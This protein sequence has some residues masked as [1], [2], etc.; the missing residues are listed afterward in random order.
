METGPISHK[1]QIIVDNVPAPE[2]WFKELLGHKLQADWSVVLVMLLLAILQGA[3]TLCQFPSLWMF[4]HIEENY[5]TN[6][7]EGDLASHYGDQRGGRGGPFALDFKAAL[8]YN[9]FFGI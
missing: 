4:M 5:I 1:K 9:H 7:Y 2:R 8:K 6:M 3:S